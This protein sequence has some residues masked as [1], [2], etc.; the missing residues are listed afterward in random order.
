MASVSRLHGGINLW[1]GLAQNLQANT[2]TTGEGRQ[3][4]QTHA[5]LIV[6]LES[7][8]S[9]AIATN[10]P[11]SHT[12]CSLSSDPCLHNLIVHIKCTSG[13]GTY[14]TRLSHCNTERA[15]DSDGKKDDSMCYCEI[16]HYMSVGDV[17]H[18]ILRIFALFV[19]VWE[20][21]IEQRTQT[22]QSKR[23]HGCIECQWVAFRKTLCRSGLNGTVLGVESKLSLSSTAEPSILER[24]RRC[25]RALTMKDFSLFQPPLAGKG[26]TVDKA[27]ENL[28]D[29]PRFNLATCGQGHTPPGTATRMTAGEFSVLT[30]RNFYGAACLAKLKYGPPRDLKHRELEIFNSIWLGTHP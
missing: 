19:R 5:E 22:E 24:V 20:Q 28:Q 17:E 18:I 29:D 15:T 30:E 6:A 27:Y 9:S 14:D 10:Q 8:S 23:E 26:V 12:R 21:Q 3:H 1:P 7:P 4:P 2:S 16:I 13:S 11:Y 25:E